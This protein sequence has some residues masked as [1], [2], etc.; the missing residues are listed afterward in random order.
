MNHCST[1]KR[2]LQLRVD[3]IKPRRLPKGWGRK[4]GTYIRSDG[5]FISLSQEVPDEVAN[6]GLHE[7][8]GQGVTQLLLST[9]FIDVTTAPVSLMEEANRRWPLE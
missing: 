2:V 4:K 1:V 7:D 6:W 9:P 8:R 5:M 3:S